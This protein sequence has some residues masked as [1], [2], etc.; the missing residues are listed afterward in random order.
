MFEPVGLDQAAHGPLDLLLVAAHVVLDVFLRL[1]GALDQLGEAAP[2]VAQHLWEGVF[3]EPLGRADVAVLAVRGLPDAPDVHAGF[4]LVERGLLDVVE[5]LE[6]GRLLDG[7][8][9]LDV[10]RVYDERRVAPQVLLLN[11]AACCHI[12]LLLLEHR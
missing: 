10:L 2:L 8:E 6:R 9:R 12:E 5:G 11:H 3:V 4:Q 7:R 1:L